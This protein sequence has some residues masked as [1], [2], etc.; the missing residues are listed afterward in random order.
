MS[1]NSK[2]ALSDRDMENYKRT[3]ASIDKNPKASIN[4][5]DRLDKKLKNQNSIFTKQLETY[6]Q[7]PTANLHSLGILNHGGGGNIDNDNQQQTGQN[8][9]DTVTMLA[10]DGSSR[11]VPS[12]QVQIWK[13]KG[14]RVVNE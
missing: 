5:L 2:G 4:I 10:P 1:E 9:N 11:Q 8:Q 3:F 6:E 12:N 7:D 13:Q 14:A